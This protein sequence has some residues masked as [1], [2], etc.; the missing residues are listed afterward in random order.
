MSVNKITRRDFLKILNTTIWAVIG[1][2]GLDGLLRFLNTETDPQPQSDFDI[3][4]ADQY[5]IGSRTSITSIPALLIHDESGFTALSLV[6]TH[7]GCTLEPKLDGFACPCH[8]SRFDVKGNVV[9]GP[10]NKPLS[11]LEVFVTA[12]GK[13]HIFTDASVQ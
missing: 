3:G 10:A 6:C 8:G 7:L 9:R 13:L 11:L 4:S 12:D 5:P 1:L 2:L